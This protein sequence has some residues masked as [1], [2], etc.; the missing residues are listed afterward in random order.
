MSQ[1]RRDRNVPTIVVM[2]NITTTDSRGFPT[3][4]EQ[5]FRIRQEYLSSSVWQNKAL[6]HAITPDSGRKVYAWHFLSCL[7]FI[8]LRVFVS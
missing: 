8:F 5:Q 3:P 2:E 6:H 1:S 4:T 7:D